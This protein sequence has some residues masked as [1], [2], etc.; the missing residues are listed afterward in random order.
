MG[1][2]SYYCDCVGWPRGDVDSEGGLSDMVGRAI[3]ISRRTF[4]L[5]VDRAELAEIE[6]NLGYDHHWKHGLTMAADWAVSYH[7]SVLHG[8]RVYFFKHSA[9]EYVFT[10]EANQ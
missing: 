10:K 8:E 7:R 4:L 3:D 5:H 9:I 2:Y 1:H 6:R